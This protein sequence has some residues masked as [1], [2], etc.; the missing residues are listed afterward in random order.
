M[1]LKINGRPLRRQDGYLAINRNIVVEKSPSML[2][3][4]LFHG[5]VVLACRIQLLLIRL[6]VRHCLGFSYSF[7]LR[8][9][10]LWSGRLL[11]KNRLRVQE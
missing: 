4:M 11:P 5:F 3:A 8:K 10:K 2:V 6:E 7:K 9:G 1:V